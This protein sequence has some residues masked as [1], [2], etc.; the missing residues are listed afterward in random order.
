M[1]RLLL[2]NP[3][4]ASPED[5]AGFRVR[6]AARAVVTDSHNNVAL[7]HVGAYD[8][9]KL[10]GGGIEEGEDIGK[11]LAREC[12]EEI[13]CHVEVSAPLGTVEEYR[14]MFGIHQISHCYTARVVGEKRAPEFTE[15]EIR[16][17]FALLW[18]PFAEAREL[19]RLCQPDNQEGQDYIVPRD[20]CILQ[21]AEVHHG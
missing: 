14:K 2:L 20:I 1:E 4:H 7:L 11:A 8:Y 9:Y 10:P 13:G 21:A 6:T 12:L 16:N 15:S 5:V 17:K 18:V 19:L 3:E